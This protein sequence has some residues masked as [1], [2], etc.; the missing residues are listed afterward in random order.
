VRRL[1]PLLEHVQ[2]FMFD[3]AVGREKGIVA[4]SG[5]PDS[6]ALARLLV[7]LQ[8]QNQVGPLILAHLNH[9]LRGAESD[10][11]EAFVA[12][13]ADELMKQGADVGFH[14]KRLD[15]AALAHERGGNLES[16]ARQ[17]RYDWFAEIARA[18]GARWVAT[19]H[20]ADDQAETIL[21]RLVRGTGLH[22]LMGIAPRRELI[23]G[24]ELLRPLLAVRRTDVLAFLESE[25]QPYRID[26]TNADVG[27]TRNRIRHE[28]LP[29]LASK[30]NPAIVSILCRL[31][32]QAG[33]AQKLIEAAAAEKL[34]SAELPRAGDLLILQRDRLRDMPRHLLCEVFRLLWAREGWLVGGMGFDD[35]QR[36]AG[37]V[38][39]D[40]TAIDLP[41]GIRAQCSG[42]VIQLRA[43]T[44]PSTREH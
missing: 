41:D 11:D 34:R 40:E 2:R 14:S 28:L 44:G 37:L 22:G 6:V 26:S 21:H 38:M 24:V 43:V 10:A 27:F 35:W 31:A 9:Q 5:G 1:G 25:Q 29:E 20:T 36:L 15:M 16:T 17:E 19:G 13:F 12:G 8:M 3:A 7:K 32:E 39:G 4:V 18:E 33:D 30:Y 42:R 23:P